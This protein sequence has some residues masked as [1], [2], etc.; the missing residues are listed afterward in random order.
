MAERPQRQGTQAAVEVEDLPRVGAQTEVFLAEHEGRMNR[1]VDRDAPDIDGSP[2]TTTHDRPG[3]M[4]MY[5]PTEKQGYVPRTV[6]VSALRLLI[7]QG[8]RETCPECNTQHI[9]KKGEVSTDPNLCSAREPVAVRVCPVCQKRIYDNVRFGAAAE[10]DG[11]LNVVQDES[12]Q[13]STGATRTKASLDLHLWTRHPREAQMMGV[14]PL[15][16]ALRDMI[17]DHSQV[18]A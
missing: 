11:D 1:T 9:N 7:R 18:T 16:A 17:A 2:I 4:I 3:T 6:S 13:Q 14:P 5:K 10:A 12:Y 8:W 15:P